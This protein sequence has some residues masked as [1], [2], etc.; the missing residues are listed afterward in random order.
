[1]ITLIIFSK[2]RAMQL[3]SLLRSI[4]DH[5]SGIDAI[6]VCAK[7]SSKL[8]VDAYSRLFMDRRP[9]D[10][11]RYPK[12]TFLHQEDMPPEL[13][14]LGK[15]MAWPLEEAKNGHIA[16]AVDDMTFYRPSDF[17][18]AATTLDRARAFTWSWRLGHRRALGQLVDSEYCPCPLEDSDP[19]WLCTPFVDDPDYRYLFH[20]DGALYRTVDYVNM[21]DKW[22]PYWRTGKYTP[23]DFESAVAMRRADWAPLVGPHVGPLQATCI[24][25]QINVV[26][27]EAFR[28]MP[29]VEIPDTNVDTLAKAFLDGKRVD[30]EKLYTAL[31]EDAFRFNPPGAHKTHVHANEEA[32]R[33]WASCIK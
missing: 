3:D 28:G 30:N 27:R 10:E 9:A 2:D 26:R 33:F 13:E 8:H 22:L 1:M 14:P 17:E 29:S 19:H 5:C 16:L 4:E 6:W 18:I 12:V 7:A 25:W 15:L 20:T 23:N 24:T 31:Q 11:Y 32:A 21:L